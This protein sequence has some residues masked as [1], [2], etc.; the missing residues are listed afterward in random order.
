MCLGGPKGAK[1]RPTVPRDATGCP[2]M[3][4]GAQGG[5]SMGTQDRGVWRRKEND[6]P[7]KSVKIE[8]F[9]NGIKQNNKGNICVMGGGRPGVHRGARRCPGGAQGGGQGG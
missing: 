3:P 5:G 6:P 7:F 2:G 8:M 4:R 9:L 1:G